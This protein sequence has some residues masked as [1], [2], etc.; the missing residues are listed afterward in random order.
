MQFLG[1]GGGVGGGGVGGLRKKQDIVGLP[2]SG[3]LR[4]FADL[5]GSWRKRGGVVFEGG[6]ILQCLSQGNQ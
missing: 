2:K 3:E 5:K 6:L 1:E 4:Q